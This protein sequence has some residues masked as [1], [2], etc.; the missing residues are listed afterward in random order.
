MILYLAIESLTTDDI[1]K[2]IDAGSLSFGTH[3]T[4]AS[5]L[6]F[7]VAQHSKI[8]KRAFRVY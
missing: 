5:N 2:L 6:M 3:G 7:V 8:N 4:K 1:I